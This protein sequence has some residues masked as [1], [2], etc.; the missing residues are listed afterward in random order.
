[1]KFIQ[2]ITPPRDVNDLS[3]EAREELLNSGL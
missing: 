3:I 2:A 1:M